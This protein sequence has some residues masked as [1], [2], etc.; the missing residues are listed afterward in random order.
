MPF[1]GGY[2][3]LTPP[4]WCNIAEILT[5]GSTLVNKNNVW[6]FFDGFKYLLKRDGPKVCTFG[7]TL[8]PRFPPLKIATTG[9]NKQYCEKT[10]AIELSKYAKSKALSPL[11]FPEKYAYFLHYLG[12][13]CQKTGRNHK[14]KG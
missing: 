9:E 10:S 4:V 13:F 11:P 1:F 8:N 5:R 2:W 6:K 14:S 7:L 3:A 12:Y